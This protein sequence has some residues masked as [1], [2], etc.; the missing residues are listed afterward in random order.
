MT[1]ETPE[2]NSAEQEAEAILKEA[3]IKVDL[4]G[5]DCPQ[6]DE[7]AIH[8]RNDEEVIDEE[9][10]FGRLI[11]YVGDYVVITS[12]NPDLDNPILLLKLAVGLV[13][14]EDIPP[15][16]ET[17]VIHVGSG[18]VADLRALG[19]SEQLS[20]IRFVQQHDDWGNFKDAHSVVVNGVKEE[21]IDVSKPA[22]PKE[23]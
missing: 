11:T 10:E 21:L 16:Y 14:P 2:M 15:T 6:G 23:G 12:D 19:K 17:C 4:T 20:S 13:K 9:A 5:E 18:T 3:F 1:D 8:H 7:C 22:Y